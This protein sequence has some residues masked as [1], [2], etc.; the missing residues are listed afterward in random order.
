M[1]YS[2]EGP[3]GN[4]KSTTLAMMAFWWYE[5]EGRKIISNMPL[6]IPYTPF[7]LE[8]LKA[9][10]YD[11]EYDDSVTI[12]D[13]GNQIADAHCE[14]SPANRTIATFAGSTRKRKADLLIAT[15]KLD[16]L[17][18]RTRIHVIASGLRGYSRCIKEKP[19]AK[20]RGT[21]IY[22]GEVCD[23]C[24]GYTD[25]D[26]PRDP[27]TFVAHILP[28]FY[29]RSRHWVTFWIGKG[30]YVETDMKRIPLEYVGNY[31]FHLFPTEAK[32]PMRKSQL[33]RM[34]TAEVGA[35]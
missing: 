3:M 32:A 23:R 2:I 4:G 34:E 33:E 11:S 7:S 19:C 8:H 15:H 35:I 18:K 16:F 13:E 21:G 9:H 31:Y 22:K 14:S 24:L 17:G 6:S 26:T 28:T 30:Q 29:N 20:C 12:W 5:N 25:K 27:R 1:I 10:F